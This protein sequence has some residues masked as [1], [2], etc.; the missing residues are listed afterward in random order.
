MGDNTCNYE[1]KAPI[2]HILKEA[3]AKSNLIYYV[4]S[5]LIM[6][7]NKESGNEFQN[8]VIDEQVGNYAL[9]ILIL[10]MQGSERLS[11]QMKTQ[12]VNCFKQNNMELIGALNKL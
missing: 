1:Y 3:L 5:I 9:K 11:F 2:N 8:A 4:R 6:Y 10:I 7:Y 12:I